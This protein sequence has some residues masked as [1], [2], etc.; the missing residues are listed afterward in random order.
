MA[1]SLLCPHV[2]GGKPGTV[3]H[4]GPL[5]GSV[6]CLNLLSSQRPCLTSSPRGV[7]LQ[8]W[9]HSFQAMAGGARGGRCL[10]PVPQAALGRHLLFAVSVLS[11]VALGH[12]DGQ[13]VSGEDR[14]PQ[15]QG[16]PVP[17][18]VMGGI[19]PELVFGTGS[20][21][22]VGRLSCELPA[23]LCDPHTSRWGRPIP[24]RGATAASG[25]KEVPRGPTEWRVGGSGQWSGSL[26]RID[27]RPLCSPGST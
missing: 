21:P 26:E 3:L 20:M 24:L 1:S 19:S 6:P 27:P 14:V 9:G 22:T 2:E 16:L 10:L 23:S 12:G 7:G 11:C 13:W 17:T 4:T 15:H 8:G 5:A 18:I 25:C